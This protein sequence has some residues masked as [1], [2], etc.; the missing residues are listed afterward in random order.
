M[1]KNITKAK[2]RFPLRQIRHLPLFFRRVWPILALFLITLS[3]AYLNFEPGTY[4]IGWDNLNPEFD[5]LMNLKRAI[6]SVWQEYRGLG[7]LGG[8]AHAAD[9]PRLLLILLLQLVQTP[10]SL[11]RYLTTFLPLIVGPLGVYFLFYH[12]LFREKLDAKTTQFASFLGALFYLLNLNTLQ[13]FFVPFETF[14]WFYGSFPFL[15]YFTI[16]YI[17]KPTSRKLFTLFAFSFIASP[18]F[19]VETVFLV[20]FVTIIP[21]IIEYFSEKRRFFV[22]LRTVSSGT[23]G[24]VIPQL[25]WL[26]PIVFFVFVGGGQITETAKIN[27]ISS[28][29]T[30][31]RNLE[32]ANLQDIALLKG[33]L[34]NY[35][36][37]GPNFKYDYLLSVWRSHLSTPLITV[38]AY[39]IVTTTLIGLYYSFKKKFAWTASFMSVLGLSLFFL[40]GGGLLINQAI[41]LLGELFRSPF[42]KFSIPLSLSFAF[43]FAIGS[44]F[45][46]DLFTFLHSRLTFLLTLFSVAVALI[47]FMSPAFSGNLVGGNVRQTIPQE[48]FD[49][50]SYLKTQDPATRIA[51]LPQYTFWGWN[52][53]D[54]GYRGSGFL[55]HGIRQPL[56]D[57]AFDVWD[58]SSEKYYEE[59]STAIFSNNLEEFEKI[60][61][62]YSIGWI[63]MDKHVISP[64]GKSNLGNQTLERF[65]ISTKFT[66]SKNFNDQIFLYAVT[67]DKP[68][69]NFL[70]TENIQSEIY[71][72]K[73]PFGS[74]SLRPNQD[75]IEKAGFLSIT[76]P[77]TNNQQ[78]AT[79][80]IPSFTDSEKLIPVKVEYQKLDN[81][82]NLR[83]TPVTP[84]IFTDNKQ[85]NLDVTP[86]IISLP[87]PDE[88]S[89]ILE[90]DKQYFSLQLPAELPY[91]TD[92]F[93]VANTYLPTQ[94]RFPVSLYSIGTS[95]SHSLTNE[96]SLATPVQCYTQKPN[97]KI[98][99]IVSPDGIS[100][101]GTDVNGCLSA[102]IPASSTDSLISYSFLYSSPSLITGNVNISDKDFSS[103]E[104]P[105]TLEPSLNPKKATLFAHVTNNDQQL[106]LVLEAEDSKSVQEIRYQ[107]IQVSIL[108]QIYSVLVSVPN[109]PAQEVSLDSDVSRIQ[110]SLPIT[111]TQ[112]DISET[113]QS[114]SLL[115]ESRNC[116]Q[117]NKGK[118]VKLVS[119]AGFFYQSQNA[120]QCD[121]LNLRHFS[122]SLNYLFSFNARSEKGLS[123]TACLENYSTRR[124]DIYERLPE[125]N[126]TQSII[127]PIANPDETPGY[128]LHLFNQSIGNRISSN[129]LLSL[130]IHP[131]PLNFLK[132]IS[133]SNSAEL[134]PSNKSTI[135]NVKYE[136]SSTHPAEFLYT[137][138]ISPSSPREGGGDAT[139][140]KNNSPSTLNLY[141]TKSPYWQAIV[142]SPDDLKIPT[143]QLVTKIFFNYPKLTK[144]AH[145]DSGLWHNSWTLPDSSLRGADATWPAGTR[146]GESHSIALIYLPQYL[147]FIGFAIIPISLLGFFTIHLISGR[148]QTTKKTSNH[149]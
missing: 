18:S 52:Y 50:F 109:I 147:E 9:I 4:L 46:L 100:L 65:L 135:S 14:T 70:T 143:W 13:T 84:I 68:S 41:P 104:I 69:N 144:L 95:S 93:M 71:N 96:L 78:P 115:P 56:L 121:S 128:T 8:Q 87:I 91:V 57:R 72:L 32:F 51:N 105:G 6:Y 77:I 30:Y 43:F 110:I 62:K 137:A 139:I 125:S 80:S 98:E 99:K 55:W 25:Y 113:P 15:L 94:S 58:K 79:L 148:K 54:F 36:D 112:Y 117:F 86:R 122:H 74:L 61:D 67:S 47:L 145:D 44:M 83:L 16:S 35:L 85:L 126:L 60:I 114:N 64:D 66:L 130:S 146:R 31:Y 73:H 27:Q 42:T 76:Q 22:S 107:D 63:L 123:L 38:I 120:I 1:A 24:L 40:L 118:T 49:L 138:T 26:L 2:H 127:Q 149:K 102:S 23:L 59:I 108:P 140:N 21:F 92:Y 97:R 131:I 45:I 11:I 48:Y 39:L 10:N 33:Y 34:F 81:L 103:P 119:E 136:I 29:E 129:L 134:S 12:Q 116:D 7:L 5:T 90:L 88:S 141:Q 75:W 53:Y 82:I 133:L 106:N 124:C 20:F 101:L 28:P 89:F 111:N 3:L 37:M 132:N 17:S 142:V 19:Y